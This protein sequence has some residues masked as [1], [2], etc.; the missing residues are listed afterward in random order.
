MLRVM[1]SLH[2]DNKSGVFHLSETAERLRVIELNSKHARD[3]GR[4]RSK[5]GGDD[6]TCTGLAL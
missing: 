6:E 5:F 1:E 3:R 4:S 2:K